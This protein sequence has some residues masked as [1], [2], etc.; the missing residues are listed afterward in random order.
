MTQ[1][2]RQ[3]RRRFGRPALLVVF[4]LVVAGLALG[5]VLLTN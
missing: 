4:L 3:I 1:V 2:A 5:I